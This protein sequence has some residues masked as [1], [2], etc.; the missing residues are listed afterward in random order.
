MKLAIITDLFCKSSNGYH[1]YTNYEDKILLVEFLGRISS[2]IKQQLAGLKVLAIDS[3]VF[4]HLGHQL[5]SS[6]VVHKP[7]RSA[8]KWREAK[9]KH[10]TNISFKLEKKY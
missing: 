6:I 10:S 2:M 7:E 8:S 5:V 3:C 4:L 9:A 1:W